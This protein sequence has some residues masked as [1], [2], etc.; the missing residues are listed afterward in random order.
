MILLKNGFVVDTLNASIE[1]K[2]IL[3][4]GEKIRR[5]GRISA[6]K[7]KTK[8]V[9][10]LEG[11]FVIPALIDIHVHSRVPGKEYAEDFSTLSKAALRGGV[12]KVLTMANTLPVADDPSTLRYIKRKAEKECVIDVFQLSALTENLEGKRLVDIERNSKYAFGFS[13][14]GRWVVST[15]LMIEAIRRAWRCGK[16]VF[17]HSHIPSDGVLNEGKISHKYKL[18]G[19]PSFLEYAAVFRD[20]VVALIEK[21][22]IHLQHISTKE[23]CYIIAQAKK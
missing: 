18:K 11:K 12:G 13:D 9:F 2:D 19:I 17:S 10:N 20:C 15:D 7:Y 5:I 23:S 3:I 4:E 21:L 6:V 16:K 22:P 1:K 8:K 14:D